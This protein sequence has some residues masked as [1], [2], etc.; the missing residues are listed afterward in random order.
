VLAGRAPA[1]DDDP[2]RI[3]QIAG[4]GESSLTAGVSATTG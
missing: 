4:T 3:G 2:H 1:E